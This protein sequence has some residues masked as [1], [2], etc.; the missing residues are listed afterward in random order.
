M[1]PCGSSLALCDSG[2][3][4]VD[5]DLNGS[6]SGVTALRSFEL[7]VTAEAEQNASVPTGRALLYTSVSTK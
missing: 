5:N 7:Y 6:T 3:N 4:Q 2:A 1:R